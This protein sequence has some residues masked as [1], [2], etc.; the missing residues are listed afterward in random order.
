MTLGFGLQRGRRVVC[1]HRELALRDSC[2]C[3]LVF[4]I[5]LHA[6]QRAMAAASAAAL[7]DSSSNHFPAFKTKPCPQPHAG[8]TGATISPSPHSTKQTSKPT[9]PSPPAPLLLHLLRAGLDL[10]LSLHLARLTPLL[11]AWRLVFGC[12][13]GPGFSHPAWR[14]RCL[15]PPSQLAGRPL[16]RVGIRQR[17]VGTPAISA[18][19][20]PVEARAALP[21]P[22][23]LDRAPLVIRA[24][25]LG[26]D[27]TPGGGCPARQS[28]VCARGSWRAH[29]RCMLVNCKSIRTPL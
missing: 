29:R 25:A 27:C 24:V 9:R 18:L 5:P 2:V 17:P 14:G 28:R 23:P 21:H 11:G 10:P 1:G 3:C 12:L 6:A 8:H 22:T 7:A 16:G 4:A 20:R 26:T 15:P 13:R 19:G